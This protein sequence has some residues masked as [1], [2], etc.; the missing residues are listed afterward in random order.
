M[1]VEGTL[2]TGPVITGRPGGLFRWQ[3][4]PTVPPPNAGGPGPGMPGP[5]PYPTGGNLIPLNPRPTGGNLVPVVNPRPTG[6]NLVP[7][8]S[9][10]HLDN[11]PTI[12]HYGRH[13]R[14]WRH[15][16]SR[17]FPEQEYVPLPGGSEGQVYQETYSPSGQLV[18][19]KVAPSGEFMRQS[20]PRLVSPSW[21]MGGLRSSRRSGLTRFV[22]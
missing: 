6:G 10:M 5:T 16:K 8:K 4:H 3:E 15:G 22:F 11:R 13:W 12:S 1:L 9:L 2:P 7:L 17:L 21:S 19:E 14:H 18:Q 20:R